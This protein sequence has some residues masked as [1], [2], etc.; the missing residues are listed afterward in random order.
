MRNGAGKGD[1]GSDRRHLRFDGVDFAWRS[2]RTA[3]EADGTLAAV[4]GYFSGALDAAA[5]S[6]WNR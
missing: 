5:C 2:D 1:I 3:L 4:N 6:T